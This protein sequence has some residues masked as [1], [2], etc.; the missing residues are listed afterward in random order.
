LI[1]KNIPIVQPV[2]LRLFRFFDFTRTT[3]IS[4]Q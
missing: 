3:I 4:Q 1:F 2:S